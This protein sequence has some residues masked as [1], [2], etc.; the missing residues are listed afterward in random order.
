M[1]ICLFNGEEIRIKKL[2]LNRKL[3]FWSI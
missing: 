3:H 2:H 1:V